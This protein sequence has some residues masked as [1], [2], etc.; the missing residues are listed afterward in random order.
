MSILKL[1]TAVIL[2]CSEHAASQIHEYMIE[3]KARF[4]DKFVEK[5]YRMTI[6][7]CNLLRI[8]YQDQSGRYV[9]VDLKKKLFSNGSTSSDVQVKTIDMIADR[10]AKLILRAKENIANQKR[11]IPI[12]PDDE[13]IQKYGVDLPV[14][15]KL[16]LNKNGIGIILEN[17]YTLDRIAFYSLA[18]WGNLIGQDVIGT[19][20]IRRTQ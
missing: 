17:G 1:I 20:T 8:A 5:N 7:N 2:L 13:E 18:E 12:F 9:L 3:A 10:F 4:S 14:K 6:E 16:Y 19:I 11:T 15:E